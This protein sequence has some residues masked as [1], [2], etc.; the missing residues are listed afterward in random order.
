MPSSIR[1]LIGDKR[2]VAL[3]FRQPLEPVEGW[4][5]PTHPPTYRAPKEKTRGAERPPPR[6]TVNKGR[7]GTRTCELDTVQSQANRM[8][9]SYR[10]ELADVIPRHVVVAGDHQADL[11][12]LP[13]RVA[14]AVVRATDL[15]A[16]IR[17]CFEAFAAG[18]AAPLARL[19]PLS[20][21]Y[22][23]WDS[24]DTRVS[25]RRAIASRIEA[26]DIEVRTRSAQYSAVFDREALGLTEAQW[27]KGAEAG[28][29]PVPTTGWPGG[30]LVRGGIVHT[31]SIMLNVLRGY[32]SEDASDGLP[33]YLLALA[34]GGLVT[35]GW[36][37]Q[38]RSGCDLVPLGSPMWEAVYEDGERRSVEMEREALLEELR[39][40][41]R[42][43]SEVARV[44]LGGEPRV[45]QYD[46]QRGREMVTRTNGRKRVEES[47]DDV[48]AAV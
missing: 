40:L 7:D 12:A 38:L 15:V 17:G 37:Y 41:A 28:F 43:W 10:G 18:D 2:L 21:V 11:T 45:H 30:V 5:V 35:G 1:R 31:A 39:A 3:R 42:G 32:R 19:S 16:E 27:R 24:R 46:P 23:V 33:G 9:A 6:Y 22:G 20:L 36:R 14:D 47:G 8:E 26:H 25:V 48:D 29:A 44:E 13:H 4:D 34:L